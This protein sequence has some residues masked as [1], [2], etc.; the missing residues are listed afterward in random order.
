GVAVGFREFVYGT[1]WWVALGGGAVVFGIGCCGFGVGFWVF[2]FFL[3]LCVWLCFLGFGCW[4]LWGCVFFFV[5]CG[6][7]NKFLVLKD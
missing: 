5:C 7:E 1:Y 4:C 2:G 6:F 3:C